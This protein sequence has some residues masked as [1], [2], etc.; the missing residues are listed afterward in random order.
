VSV[1]IFMV[2]D[3]APAATRGGINEIGVTASEPNWP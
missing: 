3:E 1:S 2:R